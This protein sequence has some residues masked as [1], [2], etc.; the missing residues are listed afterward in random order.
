MGIIDSLFNCQ[1]IKAVK[2]LWNDPECRREIIRQE[3]RRILEEE[4]PILSH[5]QEQI[6]AM[7]Y[8]ADF[9]C[10]DEECVFVAGMLIRNMRS[11]DVFPQLGELFGD[12][13]SND[14]RR[15]YNLLDF[16]SKVF[17]STSL[18]YKGMEKMHD[19]YSAPHLEY[20]ITVGKK[21][22]KQ[23]A[24]LRLASILTTGEAI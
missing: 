13:Y 1:E 9:S 19:K 20:Y 15:N 21:H 22:L 3:G 6:M 7:V 24:D 10:S 12:I 5:P 16:A 14:K 4:K 11:T 2:S 8:Q 17:V 18:F 23:Q